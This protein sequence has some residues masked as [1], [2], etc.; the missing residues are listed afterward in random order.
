MEGNHNFAT[1]EE[2]HRQNYHPPISTSGGRDRQRRL[3]QGKNGGLIDGLTTRDMKI[4]IS[5]VDHGSYR[6]VAAQRTSL[7]SSIL[8]LLEI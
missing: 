3:G 7:G 4:Q 1:F 2:H 6:T 8:V 5:K